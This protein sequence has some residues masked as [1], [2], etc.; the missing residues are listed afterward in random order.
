M[1]LFNVSLSF[2]SEKPL[3]IVTKKALDL[4]LITRSAILTTQILTATSSQTI[5]D[6][7]LTFVVLQSPAWGRI[8]RSNSGH[9]TASEKTVTSFTKLDLKNGLVRYS[10]GNIYG[11]TNL[12]ILMDS[13]H[14]YVTDGVHNSSAGQVLVNISMPTYADNVVKRRNHRNVNKSNS[15]KTSRN[16]QQTRDEEGLGIN[17]SNNNNSTPFGFHFSNPNKDRGKSSLHL[18]VE[19]IRVTRKGQTPFTIRYE[20]SPQKR[21]SMIESTLSLDVPP[22]HGHLVLLRPQQDLIDQ[23]LKEDRFQNLSL[24]DISNEISMVYK[25]DGSESSHDNFV[26]SLANDNKSIKK[27]V[28]VK[29]GSK[30]KMV[31]LIK[32]RG[33]LMSD[34]NPATLNSSY[35]VVSE[36]FT[37]PGEIEY[38]LMKQPTRGY[39][40][41]LDQQLESSGTQ[42]EVGSIFTQLDVNEN[43]VLYV[44]V[45][46]NLRNDSFAFKVNDDPQLHSF[47]IFIKRYERILP[48]LRISLGD[49]SFHC[50]EENSF[51]DLGKVDQS[52]SF[53]SIRK[54]PLFGV[55]G[56]QGHKFLAADLAKVCYY[57]HEHLKGDQFEL[58]IFN[59]CTNTTVVSR[60]FL[61]DSGELHTPHLDVSVPLMVVH[62]DRVSLNPSNLQASSDGVEASRIYFVV[63]DPPRHGRL[64]MD[65]Q[66]V[67]EFSQEDI[68]S[69]LISYESSRIDDSMMDYFL[70]F[71]SIDKS[72]LVRSASDGKASFFSI[73]IQP[74][75]KIPPRL[76]VT[77][78]HKNLAILDNKFVFRIDA[79][80]LKASHSSFSSRELVYHIKSKT[81]HGHLEFYTSGRQVRR[82]FTQKDIDDNNLIFV[83]KN[84]SLAVND[85]FSFKLM[86]P[87][88]NTIDNQRLVL[89][90]PS[91]FKHS[92]FM[93]IACRFSFEWSVVEFPMSQ[94]KICK[95]SDVLVL[96]V[97]RRG[98]I[99]GTS[100]VMI[101]AKYVSDKDIPDHSKPTDGSI[102]FRASSHF[103]CCSSAFI[104]LIHL[105]V[106]TLTYKKFSFA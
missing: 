36:E 57:G 93:P 87:N 14:V 76:I 92:R 69:E 30:S 49:Q 40:K 72:P 38:E 2:S 75:S 39:L 7:Q 45:D 12:G 70:F 94:L 97:L 17:N 63:V 18:K 77:S 27:S 73:L 13:F 86:D 89:S 66:S 50:L 65:G 41:I 74:A 53:V 32:N 51:D 3:L 55:V 64:L 1:S 60:K 67:R 105:G 103:I 21:R 59:E 54:E 10:L 56:Q 22:T 98:L 101:R 11:R 47:N 33:L 6:D 95:S 81:K 99:S 80:H 34:R 23:D 24:T 31:K 15:K 43:R 25:H 58:A 19:N 20:R 48:P 42:L 16:H 96:P 61:V 85:S 9:V 37:S 83:L 82:R 28:S 91:F 26:L 84:D 100:S 78:P 90:F 88:K 102:T 35:L 52:C 46:A 8:V 4:D 5:P 68:N 29:I 106:L 104:S 71:V 44:P 62:G 79:T